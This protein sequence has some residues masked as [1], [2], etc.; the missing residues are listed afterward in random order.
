MKEESILNCGNGRAGIRGV[1]R[2][3]L[4]PAHFLL[5]D[6]H[7]GTMKMAFLPMISRASSPFETSKQSIAGTVP[8]CL[9]ACQFTSGRDMIGGCHSSSCRSSNE[10]IG[11][12]FRR[13]LHSIACQKSRLSHCDPAKNSR[14]NGQGGFYVQEVRY[15]DGHWTC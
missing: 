6:I 4:I 15:V 3:C 10:A 7:R 1:F 5:E 9:R 12:H 8:I 2:P 11:P 13:L 14:E